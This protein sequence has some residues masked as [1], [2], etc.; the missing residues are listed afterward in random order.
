M[1]APVVV[2]GANG[3][4][5]ADLCRT[6]SASTLVPLMRRDF[7][8]R[9]H[10]KAAQILESLK[11]SV[12][13]NTAAFHKVE[14]CET[15]VEQAFEV[16]CLAVRNLAQIA[17]RI[18]A[19]LVHL[20]TDYVF[21]GESDHPY[22]EGAPPNPLNAYGT[23]KVAGEFFVR[24]VCE[25]HLIVRTS[26]LYGI[27]GSSSKGGNFV[28]TMLRVGRER[29]EVSV[30]RDQLL[31]PTYTQDLAEMIWRLVGAEARGLYHVTNSGWCSWYEF[32]RAIFELADLKVEV[33]PIDTS[34]SG[35]TVR[36]PRFSVLGNSRLLAEGFVPLRSWQDALA[37][38]MEA[39]NHMVPAGAAHGGN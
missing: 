14:A 1:T 15:D 9:D 35:S 34:A 5:G 4:L 22:S 18:K 33:R 2:V 21:D 37:S 16:N 32:T 25:Q 19:L 13:I 30:V 6:F 27:A 31:S 29:S 10:E 8:V 36:R 38:Y 26:G 17:D 3:Q 12:I 7:D 20:S 23:S 11:P 24:S 39:A 28:Q